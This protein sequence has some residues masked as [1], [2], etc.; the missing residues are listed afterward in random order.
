MPPQKHTRTTLDIVE[1]ELSNTGVELQEEGEGLAN[2]TTG[3]ENGDLGG[4]CVQSSQHI[5]PCSIEA[6]RM[7]AQQQQ[8]PRPPR[9][10]L[11]EAEKARFWKRELRDRRAANIMTVVD[12]R[13]YLKSII[14]GVRWKDGDW[15]RREE[16]EKKKKRRR[17]GRKRKAAGED[18][19]NGFAG[20][21]ARRPRQNTGWRELSDRYYQSMFTLHGSVFLV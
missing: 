8:R 11:A 3:T 4:L 1:G 14:I 16:E 7:K 17:E 21:D 5:I 20:S 2:A 12:S 9:T 15:K 13:V 6:T 19:T 18:E 10:W